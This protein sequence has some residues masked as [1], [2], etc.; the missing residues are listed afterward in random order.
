VLISK[1]FIVKVLAEIQA[2]VESLPKNEQEELLHFI[3]ARLGKGG[4]SSPQTR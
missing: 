2:A 1:E 3:E 4:G